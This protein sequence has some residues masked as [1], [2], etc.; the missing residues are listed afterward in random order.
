MSEYIAVRPVRLRK[1]SETVSTKKGLPDPY[2]A[3]WWANA[4][5]ST[6]IVVLTFL[7]TISY[8]AGAIT[9]AALT[10]MLFF[11]IYVKISSNTKRQEGVL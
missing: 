6:V 5:A 8:T 3:A 2:V 11:M 10:Y 9:L 1:Q 4:L 7:E